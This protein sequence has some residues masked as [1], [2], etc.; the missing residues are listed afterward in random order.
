MRRLVPLPIA[1]ALVALASALPARAQVK[2]TVHLVVTGGPNAGSWDA[3]SERGGCSYGLA[4]AGT[5]GNQLSDPK[6]KDPKHFNSLQ[7]I[8][9]NAK[10]AAAGSHEF[11]LMVG[12]GPLL[13]RGAEY[14]VETRP[15]E[16]K[17]SGSGTVTVV[18][19]G[20]T[21][22]VTFSATTAEGVK[23]EGT[24]DCKSVARAG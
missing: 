3:T 14:K 21:G 16:A 2:E 17:R 20:T 18:D 15:S 12:F 24:I 22:K 19:Q 5:W 8:V 11:F 6:D 23:L 13:N 1:V 7:L 4:G 10:A 9:P